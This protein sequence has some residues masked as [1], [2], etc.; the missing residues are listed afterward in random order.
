[1]RASLAE[2]HARLAV[3]SIYVTHDQT[4]AMTLGQR[5]AVMSE[6]RIVQVDVPQRLYQ[7]P[8]DLFVAAFIGSPS[9]NLV[10]AAVDSDEVAF[11]QFRVPLDPVRR[12]ARGVERVVLGI[13]PES[14]DDAAVAPPRLPR[15]PVTV[16]VLEELGSDA[17][18]FFRVEAPRIAVES[19]TASEDDA[20]LLAEEASRFAARVNPATT[21][22]VGA[23]LELAVDPSSFHFFDVRTGESLTASL[24][25][26][27]GES[28]HEEALA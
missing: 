5:V 12:P 24:A 13:R 8:R 11:G 19:R 25:D 4:E 1:M 3:T 26:A 16:D 22:R 6:G 20:S 15:I 7:A 2:L 18:V 28:A 23:P 9:M 14:F 10:E 17:Y 27:G 21:A